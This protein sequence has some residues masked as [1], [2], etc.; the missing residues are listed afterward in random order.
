VFSRY[1]PQPE[2]SFAGDGSRGQRHLVLLERLDIDDAN[3]A[4]ALKPFIGFGDDW[5]YLDT[6]LSAGAVEVFVMN[7]RHRV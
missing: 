5:G 6:R 1:V 2:S 3:A 4:L 7:G